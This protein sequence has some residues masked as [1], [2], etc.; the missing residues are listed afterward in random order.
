MFRQALLPDKTKAINL[1]GKA[2]PALN[3]QESLQPPAR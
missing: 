3:F 1:A 2:E